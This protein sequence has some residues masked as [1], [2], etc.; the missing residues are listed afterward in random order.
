VVGDKPG[1]EELREGVGMG[2]TRPARVEAEVSLNLVVPEGA[3]LPVQ[4]SLR[5]EPRDP[6][7]VHVVFHASDDEDAASV[8]WTFARE[9]L[10]EGMAQ[11]AG[12]GDVRVWPWHA[13]DGPV[14][15]LALSS[16]DGHALFH[17]PREILSAFLDRTF[18]VVPRGNETDHLDL[19]AAVTAL[20]G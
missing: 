10:M 19:D 18:A 5:Y 13:G 6:Y 12:M 8:S 9:L 11:P 14:V 17:V 4:A 16:P 3:A 2:Q 20:L 15:A 1:N 7:A